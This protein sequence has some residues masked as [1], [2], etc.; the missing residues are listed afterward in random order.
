MLAG[1]CTPSTSV[2]VTWICCVPGVGCNTAPSSPTPTTVPADS[3]SREKKRRMRS[4]SSTAAGLYLD[5][6]QGLCGEVQA[7]VD[8]L[9]PIGR[10]ETLGEV[11][12]FVNNDFV[13]NVDPGFEFMYADQQD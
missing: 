11:Y 2:S 5:R 4:N 10:T 6:S 7:G 8:V 13:G 9:V 1:K 12:T 3:A